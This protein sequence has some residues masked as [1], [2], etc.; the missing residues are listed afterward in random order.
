M[1]A[2]NRK[3]NTYF[4]TPEFTKVVFELVFKKHTKKQA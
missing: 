1:L 4:K 3:L 2:K